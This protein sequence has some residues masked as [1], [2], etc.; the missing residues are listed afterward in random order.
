MIINAVSSSWSIAALITF[1][2]TYIFV[3]T[4]EFTNLR[5]SKPVLLAAG[6]I[7]IFV[8]IVAKEHSLTTEAV[9][10]IRHELEEYIDIRNKW[11]DLIENKLTALGSK[12]QEG[13]PIEFR[14]QELTQTQQNIQQ[15]LTSP[16][17]QLTSAI[18]QHGGY[19]LVSEIDEWKNGGNLDAET[20]DALEFIAEELGISLFELLTALK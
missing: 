10:F 2:I 14:Q 15:S 12:M 3:I 17:P 1:V 16:V 20:R 13:A 18:M 6:L 9:T 7:W 8:S 19:A 11:Q 4:E 5:K